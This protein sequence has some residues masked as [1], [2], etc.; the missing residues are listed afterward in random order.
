MRLTIEQN[1][2]KDFS[3]FNGS[4]IEYLDY[5]KTNNQYLKTV[6]KDLIKDVNGMRIING[7]KWFRLDCDTPIMRKNCPYRMIGKTL[8]YTVKTIH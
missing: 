5:M 3:N 7:M 8:Y 4:D 6:R 1:K 2:D